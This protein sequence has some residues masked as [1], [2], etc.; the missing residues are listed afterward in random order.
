MEDVKSCY[1]AKLFNRVKTRQDRQTR[2]TL[3]EAI[4]P[5]LRCI[6]RPAAVRLNNEI[7]QIRTNGES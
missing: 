3:N 1:N 6:F 2:H 7:I 4:E 5:S